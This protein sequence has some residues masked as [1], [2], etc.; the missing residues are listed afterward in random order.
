MEKDCTVF[1]IRR[2]FKED[3]EKIKEYSSSFDFLH[4]N[5]LTEE[6]IWHILLEGAFWAVYDGKKAVS[7]TYLLPADSTAFTQLNAAWNVTDLLD[8]SLENSL[9]CGY[10]HTDRD[11][12]GRDIYTA[13]SKLWTVQA[14]RRGRSQMIHFMP[15]HIN[16][17]MEK[18][19]NA[20][21]ELVGLRGLDN[22]VPHYIFAKYAS[23]EKRNTNEYRDIKTVSSA[24]TKTI[25][26]LCEKGYKGFDITVEKNILFLKY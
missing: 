5:P 19:L 22:L 8:C 17:D 18:L 7:V 13:L 26:M 12:A 2:L 15:A 23:F 24:D 16:F 6:Y 4:F 3:M 11:Y 1:T 14:A 25:S 10:V 21:F 20:G 9:L